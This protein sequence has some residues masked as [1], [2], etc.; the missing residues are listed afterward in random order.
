MVAINKLNNSLDL[1]RKIKGY[2][3]QPADMLNKTR[4]FDEGF[5]K[6]PVIAAKVIP[7]LVDFYQKMEEIFFNMRGFFEGLKAQTLVRLDQLP[8]LSNNIE[9]LPTL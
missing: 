5:A 3:K 6:N 8:N 4:L 2:I 9:E 7:I 1:V